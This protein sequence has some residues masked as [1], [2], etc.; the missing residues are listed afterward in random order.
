MP[1][2]SKSPST[3]S[4]STARAS[5]PLATPAV[6]V[7]PAI[8][9]IPTVPTGPAGPAISA[10]PAIPVVPDVPIALITPI[11]PIVP[12][13]PTV[14]TVPVVDDSNLQRVY[15]I[16]KRGKFHGFAKSPDTLTPGEIQEILEYEVVGT[17]KNAF[18]RG[19]FQA[20]T[21]A[22]HIDQHIDQIT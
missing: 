22:I 12:T 13:V 2:S 15:W 5:S 20:H 19:G 16:A 14:P 11:V 3:Q 9:A 7:A 6:P 4:S 21:I 8:P 1:R 18:L 17:V 10:I